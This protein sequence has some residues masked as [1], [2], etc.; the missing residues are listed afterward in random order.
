VPVSA[1]PDERAVIF[2]MLDV[3]HDLRVQHRDARFMP[4]GGEAKLERLAR[5]RLTRRNP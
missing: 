3:L 1:E 4:R 2:A 5:C